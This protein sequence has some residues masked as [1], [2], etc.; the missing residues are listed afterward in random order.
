MVPLYDLLNTLDCVDKVIDMVLVECALWYCSSL[1]MVLRI[2]GF[3]VTY[4]P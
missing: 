3:S 2:T 4:S 1:G